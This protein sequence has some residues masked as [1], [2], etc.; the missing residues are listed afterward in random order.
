MLIEGSVSFEVYDTTGAG[1]SSK[2]NVP[3]RLMAAGADSCGTIGVAL[4]TNLKKCKDVALEM[5]SY[6]IF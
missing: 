6:C 4:D 5:P 2:G 3:K 1:G